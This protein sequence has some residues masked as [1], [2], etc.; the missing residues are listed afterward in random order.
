MIFTSRRRGSMRNV[1]RIVVGVVALFA[2]APVLPAAAV[3]IGD[4]AP[5]FALPA[6]TAEKVSLADYLG[7]KNVVLFGFI[8][9]FTPT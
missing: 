1:T 7:K 3:Q 4:K 5:A 2:G 8:G 6:T 9:A